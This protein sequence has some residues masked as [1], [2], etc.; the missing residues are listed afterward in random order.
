MARRLYR[1]GL[2]LRYVARHLGVSVAD[3]ER[4]CG[5]TTKEETRGGQP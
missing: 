2:P 3:V 1:E 4:A 5:V